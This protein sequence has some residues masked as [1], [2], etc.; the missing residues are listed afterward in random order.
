MLI[1]RL[2]WLD[3][4][5]ATISSRY[6]FWNVDP[7]SFNVVEAT[8]APEVCVESVP[9]FLVLPHP[10]ATSPTMTTAVAVLVAARMRR[11]RPVMAWLFFWVGTDET[12]R[13]ASVHRLSVR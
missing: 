2:G 12:L 8:G 4:M 11:R 10:A 3:F 7:D 9:E 6:G 5:E 1:V 13:A